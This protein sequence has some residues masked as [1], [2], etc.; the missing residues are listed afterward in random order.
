MD[1]CTGLGVGRCVE[2][3]GRKGWKERGQIQHIEVLGLM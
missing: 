1:R 3:K 2:G